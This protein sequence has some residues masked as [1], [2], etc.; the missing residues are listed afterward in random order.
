MLVLHVGYAFVPLGFLLIGASTVDGTA[1]AERGRSRLDHGCRRPDDAGG[2]DSGQASAI[3]ASRC[4]LVTT[5]A[6]YGF[7]LLAAVLRIVAAFAGSFV[8]IEFAG[9]AWIAGFTLFVLL[10]A[11]WRCASRAPAETELL[12]HARLDRAR[13][14]LV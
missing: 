1:A 9:V 8:M 6:I 3:P 14:H 11:C 13:R 5:R 7:V 4:R 2:D 12:I 10:Y